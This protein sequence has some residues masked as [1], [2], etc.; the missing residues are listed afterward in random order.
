MD[1]TCECGKEAYVF[2][3]DVWK[4]PNCGDIHHIGER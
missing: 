3:G 2:I 4:C 1:I